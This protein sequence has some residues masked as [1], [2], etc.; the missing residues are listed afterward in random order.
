MQR[1][2]GVGE[3]P[4]ARPLHHEVVLDPHAAPPRDV[5][6]RLDGEHHARLEHGRR[7][8]VEAWVFVSFQS[9]TVPD[10]VEEHVAH[11][12]SLDQLPCRRVD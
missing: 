12:G 2:V 7:A 8:R 6:P 11:A 3:Q 5:D 4:A 9:E 10:P 1:T